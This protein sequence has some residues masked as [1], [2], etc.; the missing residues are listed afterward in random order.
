[1]SLFTSDTAAIQGCPL[2]KMPLDSVNKL[3]NPVPKPEEEHKS[4][5][6]LV[7]HFLTQ[8]STSPP[9]STTLAICTTSF[10]DP[11]YLVSRL[12][13]IPK[14]LTFHSNYFFKCIRYFPVVYTNDPH[15]AGA[16]TATISFVKKE[17]FVKILELYHSFKIRGGMVKSMSAVY[18]HCCFF[19]EDYYHLNEEGQLNL[20][21][22]KM[23]ITRDVNSPPTNTPR[24]DHFVGKD[25]IVI[26]ASN[27]DTLS[28]FLKY[29]FDSTYELVKKEEC[30]A[31]EYIDPN[32]VCEIHINCGGDLSVNLAGCKVVDFPTVEFVDDSNVHQFIEWMELYS[33]QIIWQRIER[34]SSKCM[35]DGQQYMSSTSEHFM[36]EFLVLMKP[37]WLQVIFQ[38][39]EEIDNSMLSLDSHV[40][41]FKPTI[42][43]SWN[44][45]VAHNARLQTLYSLPS[46]SNVFLSIT[47]GKKG[48]LTDL[49]ITSDE[50]VMIRLSSVTDAILPNRALDKINQLW[51]AYTKLVDCKEQDMLAMTIHHFP[52]NGIA[53][54]ND[55]KNLW[56]KWWKEFDF[57]SSISLLVARWDFWLGLGVWKQEEDRQTMIQSMS[58]VSLGKTWTNHVYIDG[59]ETYRYLD[60]PLELAYLFC[61][62]KKIVFDRLSTP[63]FGN[64]PTDW[65]SLLVSRFEHS[66]EQ[67]WTPLKVSR[68]ISSYFLEKGVFGQSRTSLLNCDEC[69]AAMSWLIRKMRESY[70]EE[71]SR[72]L[73]NIQVL[74]SEWCSKLLSNPVD[75]EKMKMLFLNPVD[76]ASGCKRNND[77]DL[78]EESEEVGAKKPKTL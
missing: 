44:K 46:P 65:I 27:P 63:M 57:S 58:D 62:Q 39:M 14:L 69:M 1:M 64:D 24:K 40:Y 74:L 8:M 21:D 20:N 41:A 12:L 34:P 4:F 48:I 45:V 54:L 23:V 52:K 6:P 77:D 10:Q 15:P 13:G 11:D 18:E 49:K 37:E 53:Y 9:W 31:L 16:W 32:M 43:D 68:K 76:L 61:S 7:D 42:R 67:D 25:S 17:Y 72:Y 36:F 26:H 30:C 29:C 28:S 78:E 51:E 47:Y 55:K 60:M 66:F 2:S 19:L 22:P 70:F 35:Y 38:G 73:A 59:K 3:M 50:E 71:L 75:Q 33:P 56:S 5:K